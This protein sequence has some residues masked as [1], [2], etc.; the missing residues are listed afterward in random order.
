MPSQRGT[1]PGR[2]HGRGD[3][4]GRGQHCPTRDTPRDVTDPSIW[5]TPEQY[6]QLSPE[7]RRARY[8]R[9]QASRATTPAQTCNVTPVPGI[10][11]A[12]ATTVD[13]QSVLSTPSAAPTAPATQPGTVLHS[14]MSNANS[15]ASLS[16]SASSSTSAA[17]T[18]D[19]ITINGVMYTR[20]VNA[21]H[22]YHLHETDAQLHPTGAL[23]DGG[24]NG[25]LAGADMRILE[26]D[27][28]AT[29]DVH[30]IANTFESLPLVQAAAKIDTRNDG[31]I[32][33]IFSHYAQRPDDG[34]TIHSKGQM[35]S[36]GLLIDDKSHVIQC[37]V[38]NEGYVM[39]LHIRNGLPY[40][41]MSQPTDADMAS[42]PHVFFCSDSPW[43]PSYLDGEFDATES[44][45]PAEAL[46]RRES[47]DPR[48]DDYG[49][50]VCHTT[51]IDH[52]VETCSYYTC[53]AFTI[54]ATTLSAFPQT[55]VPKL[56]DLNSLQPHFG[57]VPTNRIKVTLDATT[58]YCRATMHYPFRKHFK[59]RFPATNIN[60]IPEWFATDTIFSDVPAHDD[61]IPGHG[62]C[63]MLQLYGGVDT[64][65]LAG[66][67][68]SS[69]AS[70][71]ETL[72]D[73]IRD[74]G[75]MKGLM[76]DN[77]KSKVSR[78][79]K[80]IQRLYMIQDRQSEP[81]YQ[82]QNPIERRIQDVKHMSNNIMDCIGCPTKFWLLCTLFTISLLNHLVKVNGAI[83]MSLITSQVTDIPA[84]LTFHFWE[85]VFFEEPDSS[86]RL[87]R[88][89]GIAAK[90]RDALT[91]LVL[92]HDTEQ[93]VVHS[94]IHHAKEPLFPNICA[95]PSAPS[96]PSLLDRGEVSSRPVLHSLSDA[97]DV[98]PSNLELPKFSPDELLGLSF[99]CDTDNG[100]RI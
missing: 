91:Y 68:L 70:M 39:P 62:G 20:H 27:I 85:E 21:T 66:Y 1:V 87:G 69:E 33:G 84:F 86:K 64:H 65:F 31:P 83:P 93:V 37:I 3:Q 98:N 56:P 47:N 28:H 63:T 46:A 49:G 11:Q 100:Q 25:G 50:I 54:A 10:V 92:S 8:E 94:N 58:Q 75:A 80:N 35:E 42:F 90:H 7:Q 2:G 53:S 13:S 77:A 71:P 16:P 81:H 40:M 72:E 88:W 36:F 59:S 12:N 24:A 51:V 55:I 79:M 96:G 61:G 67:P 30:G 76:S 34:S 57:W 23:V 73:F 19:S 14:M 41:S 43:D 4:P 26:S 6:S 60:R 89:V 18:N 52:L 97:L 22:V 45:L 17:P 38:T 5:L 74:H 9:L 29:A 32:I 78:A 15:C 82:H 99:L 95:C 48:L 44:E